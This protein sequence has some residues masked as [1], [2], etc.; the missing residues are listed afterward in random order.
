MAKEG[1]RSGASPA[2]PQGFTRSTEITENSGRPFAFI[3][4][5][6]F[7]TL[8]HRTAPLAPSPDQNYS[9]ESCR[10][11]KDIRHESTQRKDGK[12]ESSRVQG[13]ASILRVLKSSAAIDRHAEPAQ[14]GYVLFPRL[15][16]CQTQ[17][18]SAG[19]SADEE[20]SSSYWQ[21]CQFKSR[22]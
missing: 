3:L 20:P 13:S 10:P 8:P 19:P 9:G 16:L 1:R 7:C 11:R 22:K 15:D 4:L 12:K 6:F 5:L 17:L 18:K 21:M 2:A 14:V